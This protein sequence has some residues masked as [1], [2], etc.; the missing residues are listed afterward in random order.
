M[1]KLLTLLVMAVLIFSFSIPVLCSD[2]NEVRIT[3]DGKEV[4]SDVPPQIVQSRTFV[5]IRFVATAL[6][7]QVSW[8]ENT[9]AVGIVKGND[10]YT[11][12]IGGDALKNGSMLPIDVAPFIVSGRTMVPIRF[13]AENFGCTVDWNEAE[14]KV[15]IV[16]G[17]NTNDGG[18]TTTEQPSS[19]T[20]SF[21]DQSAANTFKVQ[22]LVGVTSVRVGL[23]SGLSTDDFTAFVEVNG[24]TTDL[25]P[26]KTETAFDGIEL[27]GTTQLSDE[28][29]VTVTKKA[30][31]EQET[32]I[33]P[34]MNR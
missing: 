25:V 32:F 20:T 18:S 19:V 2:T 17:V 5:P 6:G 12:Y 24:V 33:L 21:I 10:K 3:L 31:S 15:I 4:V 1:K 14:R 34:V 22:V 27:N 28:V 26:N 30:T 29:K 11:L 16:S 7:A 13:I 9:R 23:K 8:D